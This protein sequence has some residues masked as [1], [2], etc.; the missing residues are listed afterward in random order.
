MT[1][2]QNKVQLTVSVDHETR[3]LF[4]PSLTVDGTWQY[5]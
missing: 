3:R 2:T 4:D 1:T 5:M